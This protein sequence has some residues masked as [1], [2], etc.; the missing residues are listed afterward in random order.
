MKN[1]CVFIGS[2]SEGLPVA[3]AIQNNMEKDPIDT[4]IWTQGVFEL[5]RTYIESLIEELIKWILLY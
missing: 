1:P 3:E 5:G 2:S 4:Y